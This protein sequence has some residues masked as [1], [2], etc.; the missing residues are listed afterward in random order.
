MKN[1]SIAVILDAL[2]SSFTSFIIF[3]VLLNYTVQ[4]PY[5]YILAACGAALILLLAIKLGLNKNKRTKIKR[6]DEKNYVQTMAQLNY[7]L[8]PLTIALFEKAFL[9]KGKAV[10]RKR[11]ALHVKADGEV[12]FFAFSF[13]GVSK[14]QIVK[15]YNQLGLEDK[16]VIW[17]ES[18]T[19]DVKLFARRFGGRIRLNEGAAVFNFLK[20]ADCLPTPTCPVAKQ[21]RVKPQAVKNLINKKRA[22]NYAVFGIVFILMSYFVP[23]KLYYLI[24]GCAFLFTSLIVRLFGQSQDS[25]EQYA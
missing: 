16:A 18:F 17:A 14:A 20:S 10:E 25:N 9:A 13:D 3:F 5:S 1:F 11:G 4:K 8:K 2:L 21:I 15:A 23:I 24:C 19:Q 12:H 7:Q 22:K 6:K